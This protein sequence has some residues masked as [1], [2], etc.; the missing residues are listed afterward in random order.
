MKQVIVITGAAYFLIRGSQFVRSSAL[1]VA[2]YIV[3]LCSHLLPAG[4]NPVSGSAL[5]YP[6]SGY[7]DV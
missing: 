6:S 5:R 7:P 2:G 1:P 4:D 3:P